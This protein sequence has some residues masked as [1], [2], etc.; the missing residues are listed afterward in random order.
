MVA[1]GLAGGAGGGGAG[2]VTTATINLSVSDVKSNVNG[3]N[4]G[5]VNVAI[6][7]AL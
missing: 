1:L 4:L 3:L 6:L 2:S 7:P 5:T